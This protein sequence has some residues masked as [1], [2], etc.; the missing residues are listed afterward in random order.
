MS[1]REL[2][3]TRTVMEKGGILSS[4]V[5]L[6]LVM[7]TDFLACA[8]SLQAK[9]PDSD[10]ERRHVPSG[11]PGCTGAA[12]SH[13]HLAQD[14]E[15]LSKYPARRNGMTSSNEP[16]VNPFYRAKD[17]FLTPPP[18]QA[19]NRALIRVHG[20]GDSL[21]Q[22]S[23]TQN[24][25][26]RALQLTS[27]Q[28]VASKHAERCSVYARNFTLNISGCEPKTVQVTSCR[29]TCTSRQRV[30]GSVNF[31]QTV[32]EGSGPGVQF[33]LVEFKNTLRCRCCLQQQV[34]ETAVSLRCRNT[35]ALSER[36]VSSRQQ[37]SVDRIFIFRQ[38]RSCA[39][40]SVSCQAE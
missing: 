1:K 37:N 21:R 13:L 28:H 29:G 16:T 12:C 14:G 23:Q 15:I 27:T 22:L 9:G 24:T 18:R 34:E 8:M 17:S 31:I 33:S 38:V 40:K 36:G 26:E 6:F 20:G 32:S 35:E 19:T 10:R 30:G 5:I 4:V 7:A 3:L 39:C 11:T 2:D 25:N